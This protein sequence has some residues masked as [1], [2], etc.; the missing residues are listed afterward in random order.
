M[1]R[2][3]AWPYKLLLFLLAVVLMTIAVLAISKD[4]PPCPEGQHEIDSY[5]DFRFGKEHRLC[6]REDGSIVVDDG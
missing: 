1:D 6:A 2:P 3:L 4:D 5:R